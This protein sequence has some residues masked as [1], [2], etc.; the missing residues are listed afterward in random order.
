[1]DLAIGAKRVFIA[2]QHTTKDG[3]PRLLR[4]C[5]LPVTAQGVVKL[6][7][8]DLGLFEITSQGFLMREIAPGYSPMEVQKLTDAQIIFSDNLVEIEP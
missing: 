6:V 4:N 7:M 3:S 5:T 1:M 8:T 2:L